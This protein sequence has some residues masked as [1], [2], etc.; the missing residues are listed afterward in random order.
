MRMFLERLRPFAPLP[1]RLVVGAIFILWGV[2]HVHAGEVKALTETVA[3]WHLPQFLKPHSVALGLGWGALV[4]GALVVVGLGARLAA[5]VL[6]VILVL[7]T[8]KTR[9]NAPL[10]FDGSLDFPLLQLAACVSLVL[11]GAG[12]FSLDRRFFGGE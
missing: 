11:S 1:V 6:A 2:H 4:G 5:F 12:R 9:L 3:G 7:W 8:V 10:V